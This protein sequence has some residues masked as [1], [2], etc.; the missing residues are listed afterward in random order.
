MNHLPWLLD[1]LARWISEQIESLTG[2]KTRIIQNEHYGNNEAGKIGTGDKQLLILAHFD[3][4][5]EKG[6]LDR[7]P[8]SIKD[9]I[10]RGLGVYTYGGLF[11]WALSVMANVMDKI[12]HNY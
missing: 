3:T 6:T 8:F 1:R 2:G 4:V 5:W 12:N 11:S 7:I 9:G 10:A